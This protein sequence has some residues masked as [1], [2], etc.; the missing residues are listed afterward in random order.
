MRSRST[1]SSG[2]TGVRPRNASRPAG[3]EDVHR[4]G[5]GLLQTGRSLGGGKHVRGVHGGPV[6]RGGVIQLWV[7]QPQHR[8]V[9]VGQ[10]TGDGTQVLGRLDL[11]QDDPKL[12][13]EQHAGGASIRDFPPH[14]PRW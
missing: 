9:E 12:A 14:S 13:T 10:Q 6:R 3:S 7:R 1:P 11:V 8:E 2:V 5:D 4:L